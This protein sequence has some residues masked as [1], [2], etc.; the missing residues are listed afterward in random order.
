MRGLPKR[1]VF[2][3][4]NHD[5][6]LEFAAFSVKNR[7]MI[8]LRSGHNLRRHDTRRALAL[9]IF[10]LLWSINTASAQFFSDRPPP[11]PPANVPEAPTPSGPAISLAPPSGPAS[12]PG[13]P[14]T[15]TQPP[16]TTATPP[17]PAASP[18][19]AT[20]S[21]SAR[22]GKDMPPISNGI[23]W[24]VYSDKPDASGAFQLIREE[25]TATPNIVLSPGL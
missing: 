6:R 19:Q 3:P 9:A 12:T 17:Q 18:S 5:L 20:L 13:L 1:A 11:I 25:R 16:V 10:A 8:A 15:L 4:I 22:Y 7:A 24:R 14:A 21:L 23:I 2:R